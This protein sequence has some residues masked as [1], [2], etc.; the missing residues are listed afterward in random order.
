M[1]PVAPNMIQTFWVGGLVSEGGEV[2][3][4]RWRPAVDDGLV[5]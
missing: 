3:A 1:W 2:V 5:G 4:G